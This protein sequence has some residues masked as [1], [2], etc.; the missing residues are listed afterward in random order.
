MR[1]SLLLPAALAVVL[2][3]PGLAPAVG[4]AR[5]PASRCGSGRPKVVAAD[6]SGEA[7]LGP[8]WMPDI[9]EFLP[10]YRGCLYGARR[11]YE[12]GI[13]VYGSFANAG[14][15]QD[16]TMGGPMVAYEQ[17]SHVEAGEGREGKTE[18][19]VFVRDLRS[20]RV[21]HRVPTGTAGAPHVIGAGFTTAIVVKGD[22]A[23]AWI[24][25]LGPPGEYQIRALDGSGARLLASGA[26]IDPHSLAL[27]GST[28]YW[29]QQGR[30]SSSALR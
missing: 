8:T 6:A 1:R 16:I 22:G 15:T 9:H 4:H 13:P 17:F 21:L 23:V 30:P 19:W 20:G 25:A 11:S 2:A 26:G 10:A 3:A 27:A 12:L 14:G 28:V 24:V 7:Y 5:K 18:F 29:T